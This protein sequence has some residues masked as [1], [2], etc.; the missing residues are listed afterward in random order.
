MNADAFNARG[1]AT[2]AET[3]PALMTTIKELR[4]LRAPLVEALATVYQSMTSCVGDEW[5]MEWLGEVW[6]Q[7]P[8]DVRALAGDQDAAAEIAAA[9]GALPVPAGGEPR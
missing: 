1:H 8:L 3:I 5:A 4:D 2:R 6:S 9:Q 7:L